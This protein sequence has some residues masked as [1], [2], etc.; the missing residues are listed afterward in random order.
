MCAHAASPV[1]AQKSSSRS[2]WASRGGT[3]LRWKKSHMIRFATAQSSP[4]TQ[5]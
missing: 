2:F 5:W 3:F 1:W 4:Y